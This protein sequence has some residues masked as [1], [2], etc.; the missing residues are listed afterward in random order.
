MASFSA[1][2]MYNVWSNSLIDLSFLVLCLRVFVCLCACVPFSACLCV[3]VSVYLYICVLAQVTQTISNTSADESESE[4]PSVVKLAGRYFSVYLILSSVCV[5][6]CEIDEIEY[7]VYACVC[8][9]LCVC[10]CVPLTNNHRPLKPSRGLV[11][12]VRGAFGAAVR[13]V[14]DSSSRGP[15]NP[16]SATSA[17]GAGDMGS[18]AVGSSNRVSSLKVITAI[19]DRVKE[20]ERQLEQDN[21]LPS[22]RAG[23]CVSAQNLIQ[24]L[25]LK[26]SEGDR[27]AT[28]ARQFS[29]LGAGRFLG[30]RD[31]G[32]GFRL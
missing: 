10:A 13:R 3:C 4:V 30:F 21:P 19:S 15:Q 28:R 25:N 16:S 29:P 26:P 24:T 7:T 9:C 23:V 22:E 5:C 12:K 32:L 14:R 1:G 8:V 31:W 2:C 27:E 20:L 11:S 18:G 17:V 6:A